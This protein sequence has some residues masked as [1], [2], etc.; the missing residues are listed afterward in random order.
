MILYFSSSVLM[1]ENGSFHNYGIIEDHDIQWQPHFQILRVKFPLALFIDLCY[2][3]SA[4][5]DKYL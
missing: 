4:H 2:L 5:I 1:K 3:P